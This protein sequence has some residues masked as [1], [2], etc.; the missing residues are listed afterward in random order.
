MYRLG[1]LGDHLQDDDGQEQTSAGPEASPC[2]S[3]DECTESRESPKDAL[4]RKPSVSRAVCGN[5]HGD[6]AEEE[7]EKRNIEAPD[8]AD[9]DPRSRE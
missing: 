4:D 1:K 6:R 3:D 7:V 2:S 9:N 8:K 5:E